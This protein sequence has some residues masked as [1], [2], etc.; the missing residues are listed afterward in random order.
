MIK[1]VLNGACHH[2]SYKRWRG[3]M[4][5]ITL[6]DGMARLKTSESTIRRLL[7]RGVYKKY[8]VGGQVRLDWDEVKES[9]EQIH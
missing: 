3:N 1:N 4:D 5:L 9:K 2:T 8:R 7:A 6:K